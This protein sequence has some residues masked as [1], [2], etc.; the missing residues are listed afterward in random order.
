MPGG[1][2]LLGE[3]TL[4]IMH[5]ETRITTLEPR[6][7]PTARQIID[8][9]RESI[10][11]ASAMN[12][13]ARL[14]RCHK[15][16]RCMWDGKSQSGDGR[17]PGGAI[18]QD[19]GK[20][21]F[22]WPG[23]PDVGIPLCDKIVRWLMMKRVS[24]LNRG[25]LR[26]APS[27][28]P[29]D[30]AAGG[31]SPVEMSE[32]WQLTMEHFTTVQDWNL[33]KQFELFSTCVEEFG[34]AI[35]LGDW[36]KKSRMEKVQIT[37][38]QITDSLVDRQ[39][40]DILQQA[41]DAAGGG[42]ID[43]ATVL[44]PEVEA[45]IVEAVQFML[46]FMLSMGPRADAGQIEM[47]MSVDPRMSEA[48]ARKVLG[49]LSKGAGEPA[50]YFAPRDDGGVP[51]VEALVPWVNCLHPDDMTG[52]GKADW[53]AVPRYW[54]E[55]RLRERALAEGWDKGAMKS[56]IENQRNKFFTDLYGQAGISNVAGW[57]LNGS[58]IGLIPDM[59]AMEKLPRWLV[60]YVWRRITTREG[61]PMIYRAVVHPN[62]QDEMLLWEP[63][64]MTDLPIVVDVAEPVLYAMQAHGVADVVVDKQNFI[65]DRMNEEGAR[66]QMGS[67]PPLN[68]TQ[69]QNVKLHPGIQL[70]TKR[71]GSSYLGSE[72][73]KVPPVDVGSINLM[74][75]AERLVDE[76]YFRGE[77]TSDADQRMFHEWVV[78]KSVRVL[79]EVYK[80]M[81]RIIQE[82]IDVLQASRINGR[83]VSLHI[84]RD[85][86]AGDAD[87]TIGVHLDGYGEDAADKF[88]EV[89][90][91]MI[92]ADRA[93][94][95]DW[96]E[97]MTIA[98]QLLAPTYA[99]RLVM[100]KD[101]ATGRTIDD[102]ENRITKIMAGVPVRY[103]ENVSNPQLRMQV[104]QQWA[105]M[106]GNV[107][108]ALSDP[109]VSDMMQKEQEMLKFQDQQQ[110]VNP[111][112][113]RTGVK[114]NTPEQG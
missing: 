24:V 6:Q 50:V 51:E 89:L 86:A 114:P 107:Q 54:S 41:V 70:F 81:W 15:T 22:R 53:V 19:S 94:T 57:A 62:M 5:E 84:T 61:R 52:E 75:K 97:A 92:Q 46:E 11:A 82:N 30:G 45:R 17:V 69:D 83:D 68:R 44:T 7:E 74:E 40:Q 8:E 1:A 106:P 73:M 90:G 58:G 63:T 110:S 14:E 60:V 36:L 99:R 109:T 85:Q 29:K 2:V 103:E 42:E 98:A 66:G 35:V 72:F 26:I 34:Y 55:S 32:M 10:V 100:T 77:T 67:N 43:P 3:G 88:I 49:Q 104:L 25:D 78:F 39:R 111:T 21:V 27:R 65:M 64:D 4:T 56:L 105:A 47:L 113:G 12:V 18:N 28:M 38:Q 93:G 108:R 37:L 79:K 33:S 13:F 101:V 23:A 96:S 9:L 20:M 95:I 71:S 80:L 59:Q 31:V 16:R 76:Y 112:T 87:I 91:K 48:E 102:Q